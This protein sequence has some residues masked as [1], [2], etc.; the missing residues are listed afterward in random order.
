MAEFI[1]WYLLYTS[2]CLAMAMLDA[3]SDGLP[4]ET[5]PRL[6]Q[7]A[8]AGLL[9]TL[10]DKNRAHSGHGFSVCRLVEPLRAQWRFRLPQRYLS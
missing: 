1:K 4:F 8:A 2:V 7:C 10:M 5:K 3:W 9:L 6:W